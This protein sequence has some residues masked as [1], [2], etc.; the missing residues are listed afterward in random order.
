VVDETRYFQGEF[1]FAS[2]GGETMVCK[3]RHTL[4]TI[5]DLKFNGVVV[6]QTNNGAWLG[7]WNNAK[8]FGRV[9]RTTPGMCG[10][11]YWQTVVLVSIDGVWDSYTSGSPDQLTTPAGC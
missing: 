6:S 5:V 9:V 3:T 2:F 4:Y 11:G 1:T 8:G 7:P 10:D